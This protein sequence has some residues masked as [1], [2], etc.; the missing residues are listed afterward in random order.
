[1]ARLLCQWFAACTRPA[2]GF[3]PH[4]VLAGVPTCTGCAARFE[5]PLVSLAGE[6]AED[7]VA[8]FGEIVRTRPYGGRL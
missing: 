8:L 6:V 7:D 3:A 1:M 2:A 5:L 4:P